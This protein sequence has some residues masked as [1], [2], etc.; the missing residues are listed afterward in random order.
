[1]TNAQTEQD[2]KQSILNV[3]STVLGVTAQLVMH[4]EKN[5]GQ[6]TQTT[7]YPV[8]T[9]DDKLIRT[10]QDLSASL[11]SISNE[12][13][14]RNPSNSLPPLLKEFKEAKTAEEQQSYL[15]KML[16][17]A[18]TA[19]LYITELLTLLNNFLTTEYENL[20]AIIKTYILDTI[21]TWYNTTPVAEQTIDNGEKQ[22]LR[23][24]QNILQ[25]KVDY[26]MYRTL[27]L[28][29]TQIF[30]KKEI[31]DAQREVL[32]DTTQNISSV[33]SMVLATDVLL[34]EKLLNDEITKALAL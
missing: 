17:T 10:L 3:V 25:E 13:I 12:E 7:K 14:L 11:I 2:K 6:D 32:N 9:I 31:L 29:A 15:K 30:T 18:D 28:G 20:S 16:L 22:D 21:S 34:L 23:T 33:V 5:N 26:I 8:R 27:L 1:M 19:R 4:N 24:P